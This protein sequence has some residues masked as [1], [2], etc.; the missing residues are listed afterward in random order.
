MKCVLIDR[1]D[2]VVTQDFTV[3]FNDNWEAISLPLNGFSIYRGR[4]PMTK[5]GFYIDYIVPPKEKP[6]FTQFEWRHVAMMCIQSTDSYDDNGRYRGASD[7]CKNTSLKTNDT[8]YLLKV[9]LTCSLE[10]FL[11]LKTQR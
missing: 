6:L 7:N 5:A 2:N 1:N 4:K 9:N 8:I 3:L 11:C 10:T